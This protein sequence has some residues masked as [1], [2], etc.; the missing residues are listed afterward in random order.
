MTRLDLLVVDSLEPELVRPPAAAP[1]VVPSAPSLEAIRARLIEWEAKY[2]AAQ[3]PAT[4]KA[5]RADWQ[6]FL[7]WCDRAKVW[8]LP[9]ASQD[10]IRFKNDQLVLGKKRYTLKRYVNT[11]RLIHGAANLPDP[12][13]YPDW[14]LDWGGLVKR[15]A[16]RNANAPQQAEPMRST[17]VQQI[18]ATLGDSPLDLRDAALISL[19]WDT[20]CRESE[21]IAI[22]LEDI[23][24]SGD[25]WAVD[26]RNSKT[27]QEGL[28]TTRYCSPETKARIDAWCKSA[29]IE[30]GPI[31]LPVGR[32]PT[33]TAPP[34]KERKPLGPAEVARILRRRAVRAGVPEGV[35]MTGHSGR[36]GSAVELLE[37]GFSVT[38][39]QY[40]GGWGSPRMVLHYGKRAL[41]GRNAMAKLRRAQ[42]EASEN[43]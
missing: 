17:H 42:S 11:N 7:G 1:V 12:T 35:L 2:R 8:A 18:L 10:L 25:A 28:G 31:F 24:R 23:K 9:L 22:N 6:V 39:V 14:K 37:A 13:H 4:L 34:L 40:A 30:R 33:F 21:L 3:A 26:L 19:A 20:L 5:V 43:D 15:L 38:D 41:A 16:E 36:V 27:D 29:G 32:A